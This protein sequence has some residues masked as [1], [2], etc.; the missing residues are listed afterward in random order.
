MSNLTPR[1]KIAIR[2][3]VYQAAKSIKAQLAKV[4]ETAEEIVAT[5]TQ[6]E[7]DENLHD[8]VIN[9]IN[10]ALEWHPE[11]EMEAGTMDPDSMEMIIKA[12]Q[13]LGYPEYGPLM[14]ER[15]EQRKQKEAEA[16]QPNP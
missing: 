6:E 11:W 12:Y 8:E 2:V 3:L 15:V 10:E 13:D 7:L 5:W 9:L 4:P 16:S 14:E 1:E